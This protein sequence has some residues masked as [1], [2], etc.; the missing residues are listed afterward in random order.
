[1]LA[2]G[3]KKADAVA[4]VIEGLV[5]SQFTA[6][7]LQLHRDTPIYLDRGAASTLKNIKYNQWIQAKRP[8]AATGGWP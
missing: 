1:M 8:R 3:E 2:N 4:A 6:S 5:T 7:A